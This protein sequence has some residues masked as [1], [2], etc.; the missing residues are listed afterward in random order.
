MRVRIKVCGITCQEDA[1]AAVEAGVDAIGLNFAA[2]PRKIDPST[3]RSILVRLPPMVCPVGLFLDAQ[4]ET[5]LAI[6][7]D[8]SI[9][10]VQLHGSEPPETVARLAPLRVIKAFRVGKEEDIAEVE[11]YLEACSAEGCLPAAVLLD[12]RVPG[13]AGGTGQ[14]FDWRLAARLKRR[15]PL[16]LAGGL[17]PDNVA[18]AVRLVRP[19]GVDAASRLESKPGRKDPHLLRRF[20]AEVRRAEGE[21]AP[22]SET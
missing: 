6:C 9:G 12:S 13:L 5:V 22:G 8:L 10:T 3:A 20:V 17:G 1:L 4:P 21:L 16:I 2:G 7:R 15:I 11:A 19:F 14:A 18:Q